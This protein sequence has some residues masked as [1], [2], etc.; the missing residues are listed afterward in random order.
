MWVSKVFR[1]HCFTRFWKASFCRSAP[2]WNVTF[3]AETRF[4]HSL[5]RFRFFTNHS[6]FNS[7]CHTTWIWNNFLLVVEQEGLGFSGNFIQFSVL[8][9]II[10]NIRFHCF[11]CFWNSWTGAHYT[12]RGTIHALRVRWCIWRPFSWRFGPMRDFALFDGEK[13][14]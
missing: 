10:L 14:Y 13:L 6:S 4:S 7:T 2:Y 1:I 9:C 8:L 5:N 11:C 3:A 12:L